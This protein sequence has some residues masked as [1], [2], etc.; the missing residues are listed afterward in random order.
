MIGWFFLFAVGAF[1]LEWNKERAHSRAILFL[2]AIWGFYRSCWMVDLKFP[3]TDSERTLVWYPFGKRGL[4]WFDR[5]RYW[6]IMNTWLRVFVQPEF[7]LMKWKKGEQPALE[8]L[9]EK[10]HVE[11]SW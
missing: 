4:W 8:A 5:W 2:V 3:N 10:C 1:L 9:L 6:N 7:D 11:F